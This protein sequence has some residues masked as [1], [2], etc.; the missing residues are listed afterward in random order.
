MKLKSIVFALAASAVMA[1]GGQTAEEKVKA[2]EET[3]NAMMTEFRTMMDSLSSDQA[4][5]QAY[6][7]DFV[8]KY[9]PYTEFVL[10]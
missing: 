3:H 9:A 7:D 5:A 2:F 8:K 10:K 6:Y 1:C 4:K